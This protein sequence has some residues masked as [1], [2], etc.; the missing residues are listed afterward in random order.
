MTVL[1]SE[2]VLSE[3]EGKDLYEATV[4]P[5]NLDDTVQTPGTQRSFDKLRM[6]EERGASLGSPF[7]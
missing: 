4:C 3:A 7:L 6:T 2:L 5:G 1:L